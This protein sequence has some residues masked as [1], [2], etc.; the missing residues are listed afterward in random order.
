MVGGVVRERG[1]VALMRHVHARVHLEV[2]L[3][4][5]VHRHTCCAQPRASEYNE[6]PRCQTIRTYDIDSTDTQY[7][8][9]LVNIAWSLIRL[10]NDTITYH[11]PYVKL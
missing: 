7:D 11:C 1:D 9:V 8:L 5:A 2:R 6:I 3:P 10:V 4:G